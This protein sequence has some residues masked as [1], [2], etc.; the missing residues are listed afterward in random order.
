MLDGIRPGLRR[1]GPPLWRDRLPRPGPE[2][3]KYARGHAL[4]LGG[5]RMTGAA[6]LAAR[7]A[8][9]AGAGLVTVACP[10][11][12]FAVYA[13]GDPGTLVEPLDRPE[14]FADSLA[15]PRRNAVL[16]GPG[17]G[18]TAQTR[19][20]VLSAL[21]TG[22]AVVLDADALTVFAD[23]PEELFERLTE[24]C[25]LT[26]HEGEFGRLFGPSARAGGGGKVERARR[27][28]E[29][30]GAVVLLK[31]PD[32]V[33]AHPGGRAAISGNGPP[34]LATAGSGDV[35]AGIIL[36]LDRKSVV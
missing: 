27:A 13:A 22:R 12:A 32:T 8:R 31:G 18:A 20:Q 11:S 25:V 5:G 21:D 10:A 24:R 26:P 35:L 29:R 28:A 34:D 30:S 4:V 16:L 17:A 15:D 2:G 3:H 19:A 23:R 7:A 9:R 6:R 36:G 33:I 14:A 1:N